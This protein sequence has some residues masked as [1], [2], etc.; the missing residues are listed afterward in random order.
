MQTALKL[1]LT[2]A[3]ISACAARAAIA[4]DAEVSHPPSWGLM[5]HLW[6]KPPSTFARPTHLWAIRHCR[7]PRSP[8]MP[9][10]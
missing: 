8:P 10:A 9:R 3:A 6:P 5:P 7:R 2:M 1:L 4:A